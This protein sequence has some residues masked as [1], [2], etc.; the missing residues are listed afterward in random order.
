[1][2]KNA[3]IIVFLL[4]LL[5]IS[6]C[7]FKETVVQ[8]DTQGYIWFSGNTYGTTAT[9]DN[10]SEFNIES[11]FYRDNRG[12]KVKKSGKAL[13]EVKPGRHEVVV[14]RNKD[15][16]VHRV[17]MVSAGATKEVRVP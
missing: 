3:T 9:I 14:K 15:I 12:E 10:L 7:G 13:Y 11:N 4:F 1:M 2:K 8:P 6:G 5:F 17:I 16:I